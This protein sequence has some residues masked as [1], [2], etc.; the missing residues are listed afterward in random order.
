M[1]RGQVFGF[2]IIVVVLVVFFTMSWWMPRTW[3]RALLYPRGRP[4][5]LARK[6]NLAS[7]WASSMGVAPSLMV[8]LETKGRRT[9]KTLRVPLVVA[10]LEGNRYLVSMLGENPDWVRNVRASNGEV[11]LRH[12]IVEL[13]RLQEVAV[14]ERAPILRAYLKRAPGAR[15]HFDIS[16][17]A[18]L[19]EFARIAPLV[20]VFRIQPPSLDR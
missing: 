18:P 7:A 3:Y 16:V 8:S 14:S 6:L 5:A 2:L 12:G 11:L 17:D 20:P 10:E 15:P 9:G 19:E 13:V 4:N 1:R